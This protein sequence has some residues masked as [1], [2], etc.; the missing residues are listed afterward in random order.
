[1][2]E[3]KWIKVASARLQQKS[4]IEIPF[5]GQDRRYGIK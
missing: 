4:E 2:N 5:Q 3:V 1:M